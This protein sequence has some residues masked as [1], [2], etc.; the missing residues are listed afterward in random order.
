M[1]PILK[2]LPPDVP[3][4]LYL[5]GLRAFHRGEYFKAH[6]IWEE[7]FHLFPP[8][9]MRRVWI[10]SLIQI[11]VFAHKAEEGNERGSTFLLFRAKEN[12]SRAIPALSLPYPWFRFLKD[13]ERIA[14]RRDCHFYSREAKRLLF[15]GEGRRKAFF[16]V[17]LFGMVSFLADMTYE[18]ARSVIGGF[19]EELGATGFIV[20]LV[21]GLG[22]LV[23]YGMRFFSGFVLQRGGSLWGFLFAGYMINLFTVPLLAFANSVKSAVLLHLGERFG[24]GLR[25]PARDTLL[26]QVSEEIGPGFGF[27]IHEALDSLGAFLGPILC[28]LILSMSGGSYREVFLILGVP[29]SM[30]MIFLFI[31][32][33]LQRRVLPATSSEDHPVSFGSYG[34]RFYLLVFGSALLGAGTLDYPLMAYHYK[35]Y[36]LFPEETIPL[37][38][39]GIMAGI[40]LLSPLLG[41]LLD[42]RRYT[43]LTILLILTIPTT[44]LV[45][46][47][48]PSLILSGVILYAVSLIY[49]GGLLSAMIARLVPKE[50][51]PGGYGIFHSIY[52]TTWFVGS[53]FLGY[54]YDRSPSLLQ[55]AGTALCALG[56]WLMIRSGALSRQHP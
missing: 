24:K 27:G 26:A 49:Q 6:E 31:L 40:A 42:L 36:H 44:Y 15:P 3:A 5:E 23:G 34:R 55:V 41:K 17:L 8:G 48:N 29:A 50:I 30:A 9:D 35:R 16:A 39:G 12:L 19:L 14:Q 56:V 37:L 43:L 4:D 1:D 18:G 47:R 20:G 54:L 25:T 32:F 21:G 52:G 10:K 22:E 11:A 28:V 38:Y 33:L 2:F 13:L 45:F 46:T 7:I 51:R 53:G